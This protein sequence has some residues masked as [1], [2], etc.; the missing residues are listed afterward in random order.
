MEKNYNV[1]EMSDKEVVDIFMGKR[2]RYWRTKDNEATNMV[3]IEKITIVEIRQGMVVVGDGKNQLGL[4]F[5]HATML[6]N[7]G[8]V[9]EDAGY[10][11]CMYWALN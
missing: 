9:K 2:I 1:S 11:E 7:G 4:S 5:R 8:N 6:L 10:G 3:E